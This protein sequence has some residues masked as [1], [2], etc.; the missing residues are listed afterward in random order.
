MVTLD[1]LL[2]TLNAASDSVFDGD[3][4]LISPKQFSRWD[5]NVEANLSQGGLGRL[6][7]NGLERA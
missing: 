6:G 5:G 1:E 3:R 4:D 7:V 2:A